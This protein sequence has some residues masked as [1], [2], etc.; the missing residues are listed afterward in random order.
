MK[1]GEVKRVGIVYAVVVDV[2]THAQSSSPCESSH[3]EDGKEPERYILVL[4]DQ[5]PAAVPIPPRSPRMFR[6]A[7]ERER[8]SER[9]S[10]ADCECAWRGVTCVRGLDV[11]WLCWGWDGG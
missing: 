10:E 3:V 4:T 7:T 9:A 2:V 1:A 8:A 6:F 5:Q 11:C